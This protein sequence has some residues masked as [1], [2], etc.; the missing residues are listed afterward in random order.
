[1]QSINVL[2]NDLNTHIPIQVELL[3]VSDHAYFWF[4]TGPGS[5]KPTPIRLAEVSEVFDSIYEINVDLF[6]SE[7]NPGVDGDPRLHVINA[8]PLALCDVTEEDSNQC[9][10]A[11]YFDH[12]NIVP[13]AVDPSS[14]AREMFVMNVDYFMSDFYFNV[15]AHEFRHMIE[16][17]LDRGEVDWVAEGSAMLAEDLNGY[18]EVGVRRGNLFLANPDQQLN[19]WTDGDAIPYYGQAYLLNKYLYSRLGSDFYR[20]LASSPQTGLRAI[21]TVAR[22]NGLDLSGID[23]WLDWLVSLAVHDRD[24]DPEQFGFGLEG[25]DTVATT[26][27]DDLPVQLEETVNQFAADYYRISGGDTL[28]VSF[29]GSMLV[30]V[31]GTAAASGDQMWFANRGNLRHMHLTRFFDLSDVESATLA[32]SVYHDIEA[33]F[34]FAY[35][36][37]SENGG[38]TWEPLVA[39]NMQGVDPADDP[40]YSALAERFYTGHSNEWR[41]EEIDLTPYSGKP[42]MIRMAYVTDLVH[43]QGGIAFDNISVPEIGFFDDG[44]R[45][46]EG[47]NAQGFER[48][49]AS[50]PQTWYLQLIT[51]HDGKP[52]VQRLPLTPKNTLAMDIPM[53]NGTTESILIVSASAPMT[54]EPAQYRLTITD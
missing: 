46:T 51:F 9:G 43:T 19:R 22:E 38:I 49:T 21:E 28:E 27:L 18:S 25:L 40:S 44:E 48:V 14:N 42:I 31:L 47:W 10:L 54:L 29:E 15:L 41:E 4:D 24:G 52:I 1:T 26:S 53:G 8:S 36:F 30:P 13:S 20:Q 3:A 32:Y 50:I 2:N 16:N 45:F 37:I 5:T 7:D 11:G 35:V 39:P 33:G 34:D 12:S 23:I 6:G 17:N